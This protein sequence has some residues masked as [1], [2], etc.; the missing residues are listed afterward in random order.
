M[1]S[2]YIEENKN[3]DICLADCDAAG[4]IVTDRAGQFSFRYDGK[5]SFQSNAPFRPVGITTDSTA[6]ILVSDSLK[7]HII[8]ENGQFL[9]FLDMVC[10]NPLRLAL[11]EDDNLYIT[12]TY[13]IVKVVRYTCTNTI[14]AQAHNMIKTI[15]Q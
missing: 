1:L 6:H 13:G 7:I 14:L 3:G 5:T 2:K 12:D 4:V 8:E 11:D 9:R 15:F 10:S